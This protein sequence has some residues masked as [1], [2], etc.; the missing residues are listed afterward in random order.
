MAVHAVR[1][2]RPTDSTMAGPGRFTKARAAPGG[3][4]MRLKMRRA[5]TTGSATVVAAATTSRK[6]IS[7]RS[8]PMPRDSA[9]SG[10][11]D[12]SSRGR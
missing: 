3:P 1:S 10:T 4:I 11:V 8:G 2:A 9:T 6:E 7:M 5:P 12:E